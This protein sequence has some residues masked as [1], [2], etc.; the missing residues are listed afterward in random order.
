VI[1]PIPERTTR[2]EHAEIRVGDLGVALD[3]Y[4]NVCGLEEVG[5]EGERVYLS[6]DGDSRFDLAVIP[7][8][9]GIEH[10]ALLAPDP[11]YLD[12]LES[13]LGEAGVQSAR[14][15]DAEPG[16]K[17][18]LGF[19]CPGGHHMEFMLMTDDGG[20]PD[21]IEPAGE[22]KVR[23]LGI[24]HVNLK[25]AEV[26][27]NAEFLQEVVGLRLSDVELAGGEWIRAW[28]RL[29]NH[30]HDVGF[31]LRVDEEEN[32]SHLAFAMR[33]VKHMQVALDIMAAAGHQIELGIGRHR[34]GRGLYAYFREPGGNRFEWSVESEQV[35]PNRDPGFY[36]Q[37]E[38]IFSAWTAQ[39]YRYFPPTFARGS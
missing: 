29:E 35:D 22:G 25:V 38:D 33:G 6:C 37:S 39:A 23:P 2:C 27:K 1:E 13:R 11:D 21:T 24:D 32:L 12:Q 4:C 15:H 14:A 10:F 36:D 16:V 26:Q 18:T 9:A 31:G 7:T 34:I 20:R 28:T 30:H 8:G 17:E 19:E 5:R 3:F